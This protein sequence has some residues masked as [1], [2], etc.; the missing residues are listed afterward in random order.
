MQ[1]VISGGL[2]IPVPEDSRFLT[3]A[4]RATLLTRSLWHPRANLRG[5][6]DYTPAGAPGDK[7]ADGGS[8]DICLG[9]VGILL[10]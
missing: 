7:S 1:G 4:S 2:L 6:R 9:N 3:P 10:L 8:L 5:L